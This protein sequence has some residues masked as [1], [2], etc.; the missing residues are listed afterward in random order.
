M[1]LTFLYKN[2][3]ENVVSM[4]ESEFDGGGSWGTAYIAD[5]DINSAFRGDLHYNNPGVGTTTIVFT[6]GSA[7][8]IDTIACVHNLTTTGTMWLTAG[9]HSGDTSQTFGVPVDGHGTSYKY[10]IDQ[11]ATSFQ[12]YMVWR[13]HLK[14]ATAI[15]QHQINELYLGRRTVIEEMPSYPFV[16]GEEENSIE[17]VSERGQKWVYQNYVR[18]TWSFSFEGVGAVTENA[19][20]KMYKYCRKN[21]QP[22]WMSLDPNNNP[23]DIKFARFQENAF[24]SEE[25]TK[26]I[27]DI[28]LSIESEI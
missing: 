5:D 17:L 1:A 7:V 19:L 16:T 4:T 3:L 15:S 2:K 8:Y 6:F 24:L 26:N 11:Y 10:F 21:T 22:F 28:S 20:Y 23:L 13:I 9:V 27:F 25:I 18:K 14:G 12:P